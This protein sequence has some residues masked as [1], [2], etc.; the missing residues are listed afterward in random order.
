MQ[1]CFLPYIIFPT[2]I[3]RPLPNLQCQHIG[4][5]VLEFL[6]CKIIIHVLPVLVSPLPPFLRSALVSTHKWIYEGWL[7][8]SIGQWIKNDIGAGVLEFQEW[9]NNN[10]CSGN[11][12]FSILMRCMGQWIKNGR[13]W[14]ETVRASWRAKVHSIVLF[15]TFWYPEMKFQRAIVEKS[16]RQDKVPYQTFE[17][18]DQILEGR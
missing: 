12:P 10:P 3:C 8:W 16:G 7:W 15:C 14:C 9:Q 6:E 13:I 11:L 1:T 17:C 4:A 2:E 5:A 18:R